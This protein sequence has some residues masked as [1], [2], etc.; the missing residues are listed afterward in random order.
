[1]EKIS[2]D[3]NEGDDL[4]GGYIVKADK[5]SSNEVAAWTVPPE[6]SQWSWINYM[7]HR[8]KPDIITESQKQYIKNYFITYQ[9]KISNNNFSTEDGAQYMIDIPSF[10]D[11]ILLN[12][13]AGNV[14]SYQFST[15]YNKER[16]GK[17]KASPV[18]DFNLTFGNDIFIWGY[19]R[20]KPDIWQHSFKSKYFNDLFYSE[21]FNYY[22]VNRWEELTQTGMPFHHDYVY[23][24]IDSIADWI[25]EAVE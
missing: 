1:M 11:F 23:N 19:D 5:L 3:D 22:L 6:S 14:D 4:T 2:T 24:L 13:Y 20:S 15:F 12:E 9:D 7:L 10:I 21:T 25:S 16:G 18:W 8:P 17:L